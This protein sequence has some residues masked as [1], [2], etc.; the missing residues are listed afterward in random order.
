[1]E[2]ADGSF[3]AEFHRIQQALKKSLFKKVDY[4]GSC[5]ELLQLG[6][7]L[8]REGSTPHAALCLMAAAHC[9]RA[10]ESPA[11]VAHHE[12]QAGK[13]LWREELRLADIND[14]AFQE[15]VP[16]ATS[17]Y[18]SAINIHLEHEHWSLAGALYTEMADFL[19]TLGT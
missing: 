1:M 5:G 13:L 12:T 9:Q 17:C 18:L 15:L 3:H 14:S 2:G 8:S 19:W 16:D 11:V 10:L 4:A 6:A 7:S